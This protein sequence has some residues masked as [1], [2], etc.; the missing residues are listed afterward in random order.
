MNNKSEQYYQAGL[1]L[2]QEKL[3]DQSVVCF[4]YSVLQQMMYSLTI[5][6][7]NPVAYENQNPLDENLPFR[8]CNDVIQRIKG[9][10][11]KDIEYIR[12]KFLMGL[13]AYRHKADYSG[14]SIT[15]L[16]CLDC[17]EWCEGSRSRL[18]KLFN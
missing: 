15:Q 13:L 12:E 18:K 17:R 11:K 14:D 10:Y 5:A 6:E 4:Y 7:N 16:E 3:Y 2:L 9:T 1:E 8:I